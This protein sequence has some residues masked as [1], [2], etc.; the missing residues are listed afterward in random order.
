M[1]VDPCPAWG[2]AREQGKMVGPTNPGLLAM[3]PKWPGTIGRGARWLPDGEATR[4]VKPTRR[5]DLV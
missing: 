4:K 1:L 5:S 3:P 2:R